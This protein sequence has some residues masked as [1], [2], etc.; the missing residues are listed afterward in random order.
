LIAGI[1]AAHHVKGEE[2]FILRRSEAYIGVMID[3]LINKGTEEPYR[4]FTSRAEYR[5]LL[6]QD[7]ADSRLMRK[8][9]KLG[10][11]PSSAIKRLD[12]KEGKIERGK[13]YLTDERVTPAEINELLL[14]RGSEPISESERLGQIL[15]RSEV[16]LTDLL[17]LNRISASPEMRDLRDDTDSRNAV[18]FE[19][20]YEGYLKR[21]DEQIRLFE[22]NEQ[23][24]LPERFD[25]LG[26]KS[27][28][29][30]GREK[31]QRI[32]PRSIGQASRISGVTPADISI[33]MISLAGRGALSR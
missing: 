3:D 29:T 12:E 7:N 6:R 33:L 14:S 19:M 10:L 24:P 11:I 5:L 9:E 16:S 32:Q 23:M 30:E 1:N 26:V 27:L 4:V 22:K 15:K 8:G 17:L 13:S 21:Q 2:P 28:S 20:K 18:Q 31:L 25:F